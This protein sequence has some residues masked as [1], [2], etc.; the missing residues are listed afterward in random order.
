MSTFRRKNTPKT[1]IPLLLITIWS[2]ESVFPATSRHTRANLLYRRRKKSYA[3]VKTKTVPKSLNKAKA[4][5]KL[6]KTNFPNKNRPIARYYVNTFVYFSA[7]CG[8]HNQMENDI[9]N[10]YNI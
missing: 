3:R 6:K 1:C 9:D 4:K 2:L 8:C 10:F 5:E 7:L